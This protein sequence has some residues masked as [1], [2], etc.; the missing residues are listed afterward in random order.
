VRVSPAVGLERR[1]KPSHRRGVERGDAA[2]A[3]IYAAQL[4]GPD[5]GRNPGRFHY[6]LTVVRERT[7]TVPVVFT[8]VSDPVTQGFVE[9]VTRPGGNLTGFS[10]YEFSLGGKWCEL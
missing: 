10:M 7:S 2:L 3:R 1:A 4:I 9:N 8:E 6:N 5:A